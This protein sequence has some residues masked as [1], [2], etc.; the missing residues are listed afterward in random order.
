MTPSTRRRAALAATLALLA[1]WTSGC[2]TPPP[3]DSGGPPPDAPELARLAMLVGTWRGEGT[4]TIVESGEVLAFVA[5]TTVTWECGGRVVLER[6]ETRIG[7][8]GTSSAVGVWSWDGTSETYRNW[9]FNSGGLHEE[10]SATF[11]EDDRTWHITSRTTALE[12]GE[13]TTGSGF[14]RYLDDD[15]KEYVWTTYD[16]TG[17]TVLYRARGRSR[18]AR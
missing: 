15:H 1:A 7:E 18:R 6:T 11:D 17:E 5:D 12:T 10:G 8:L 16:A 4:T 9:R 14:M 3:R 2:A 13:V